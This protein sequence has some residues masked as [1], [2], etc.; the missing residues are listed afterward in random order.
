MFVDLLFTDLDADILNEGVAD[1]VD[2]EVLFAV[3]TG[4]NLG[5]VDLQKEGGEEFRLAGDETADTAPEIWSSVEWN[6]DG[7]DGKGCVA[8]VDL[9]EE[10]ELGVVREKRVLATT[11]H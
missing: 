1:I 6:G 7:L 11:G 5:K 9:L 4:G 3:G 10:C 2:P 8:T